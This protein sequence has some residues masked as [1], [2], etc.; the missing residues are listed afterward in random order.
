MGDKNHLK[1]VFWKVKY[2]TTLIQIALKY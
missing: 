2:V 1:N